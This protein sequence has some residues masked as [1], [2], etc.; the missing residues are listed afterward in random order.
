MLHP[1]KII[2]VHG[3]G[4]TTKDH[5]WY[6]D[7][8]NDFKDSTDLDVVL[9]TMPDNMLARSEIWLPFIKN[10]AGADEQSIIVGHSSGGAAAMR[11]AESN[12]IFGSV[13]VAAHFSDFGNQNEAA[14]GYFN[15]P[16]DWEKI[17]SNQN[18][19]I[20]Y[21]S[22]NDPYINIEHA[23]EIHANLNTCYYER[24][25]EGH[26]TNKRIKG[27][28][29]SIKSKIKESVEIKSNIASWDRAVTS[30]KRLGLA[31][32]NLVTNKD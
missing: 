8:A 13:L 1:N 27:L 14:S 24:E 11:F 18:W 12:K 26:F 20:Q 30:V 23:R 9:E 10:E 21:A 7:L 31:L 4:G 16:W 28:A 29:N 32:L 19:I 17:K 2:I 6:Q 3:N 5:C 15:Q 25:F 22:E